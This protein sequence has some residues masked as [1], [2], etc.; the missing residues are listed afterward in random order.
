[1]NG[2]EVLAE[3]KNNPETKSIPVVL[4]S[5]DSVTNGIEEMIRTGEV[6]FLAKPY[7]VEQLLKVVDKWL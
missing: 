2:S 3:L 4:V 6:E 5:E 1:M 7:D